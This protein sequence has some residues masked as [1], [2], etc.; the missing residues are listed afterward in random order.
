[1]SCP[2]CQ[3][4]ELVGPV[5]DSMQMQIRDSNGEVAAE[6]HPGLNGFLKEMQGGGTWTTG[7][8]FV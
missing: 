2:F 6:E 5:F 4:H 3:V 7:I 8:F 1:M